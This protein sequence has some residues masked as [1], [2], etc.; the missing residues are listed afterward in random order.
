MDSSTVGAGRECFVSFPGC[1][2]PCPGSYRKPRKE[3][4]V[5]SER[6]A[7]RCSA[8][9]LRDFRGLDVLHCVLCVT[10][11]FV[12]ATVQ[13]RLDRKSQMALERLT[14]RL[15]WSPSRVVREGLRLLDACYRRP[16]RKKIIGVGRFASGIPDLGS[17]KRRLQGFGR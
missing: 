1:G 12:K 10:L 17:D 9:G 3:E 7:R 15:G 2:R 11:E 4:A 6:I 13:A 16:L 8:F 5:S 14:K